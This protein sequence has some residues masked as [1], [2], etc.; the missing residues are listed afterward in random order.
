MYPNR[1]GEQL[2]T[3]FAK[4]HGSHYLLVIDAYSKWPDIFP[5]GSNTTTKHTAQCLLRYI[6]TGGIPEVLVSD[7]GPQFTS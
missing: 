1:P 5:M 4:L 2:H 7:N 6:S 3:D